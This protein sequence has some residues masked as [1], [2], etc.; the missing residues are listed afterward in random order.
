[1][2]SSQHVVLNI[3]YNVRLERCLRL[4]FSVGCLFVF[5]LFF[6]LFHSQLRKLLLTSASTIILLNKGN[7]VNM[8]IS[9]DVLLTMPCPH[10]TFVL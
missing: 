8:N 6:L 4:R 10:I 3:I 9:L 5:F 7:F 1:M 2:Q